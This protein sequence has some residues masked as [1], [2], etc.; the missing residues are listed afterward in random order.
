ME[1][2]G[3]AKPPSPLQDALQDSE[4]RYR[5][6]LKS[7][8]EG[9]LIID[10]EGRIASYNTSAAQILG[11]S[12]DAL[13]NQLAEA[14][15]W[16]EQWKPVHEDGSPFLQE[17][18]PA[19]VTLKT[20]KPQSDVI[21]GVRKPTGKRVW[22][23][24]NA[25]PLRHVE[26]DEMLG[27]VTTFHDIT[28]QRLKDQA[29][30]RARDQFRRL[31]GRIQDVREEER[32]RLAREVHDVLGQ[33]MTNIGM[34]LGWIE[35]GLDPSQ[36]ELKDRALKMRATLQETIK[37][38]RRIASDLR[39][40]ILDDIGVVAALEW[41][42][43]LFEERSGI[44][45]TFTDHTDYIELD[46]SRSTALYRVF[47]ELLTNVA[48]HAEASHVTASLRVA[49]HALLLRVEDDGV[50]LD[51]EVLEAP[52]SLGVLGMRERL[53]PWHGTI[54]FERAPEKGTLVSVCL[55]LKNKTNRT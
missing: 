39:P 26:T 45:C 47:Q 25:A 18:Y 32:T 50:G 49:D 38:I 3:P 53:V 2:K 23:S 41:E 55:P 22:L 8:D 21:I 54:A 44:T 29:L 24:V 40:G 33:S 17:S 13:I 35:K 37:V 5:A 28:A 46:S 30:K 14:D 4:A 34:Q 12:E 51:P 42:L 16:D 19:L 20:G 36:T 1:I 7:M 43:Q 11:V 52:Q 31:S 15:H 48:R 10:M 27:V 9:V 6:V